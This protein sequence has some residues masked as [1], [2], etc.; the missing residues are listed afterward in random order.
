MAKLEELELEEL[1]DEVSE[2]KPIG[3]L[4]KRSLTKTSIVDND[5]EL[6]LIKNRV[7]RF[8]SIV[9]LPPEVM[10][11]QEKFALQLEKNKKRK[12][13]KVYKDNKE[14]NKN[15]TFRNYHDGSGLSQEFRA[16]IIREIISNFNLE[17][18]INKFLEKNIIQVKLSK[19]S[20]L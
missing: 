18:Y 8:L 12:N 2:I 9:E 6:D 1:E 3:R 4:S 17:S 5:N 11:L 16:N 19:E 7:E 13:P 10:Q 20:L 14:W 15:R